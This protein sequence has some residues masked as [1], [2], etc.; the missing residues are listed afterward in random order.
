MLATSATSRSASRLNKTLHNLPGFEKTR[1]SKDAINSMQRPI[2]I[3]I[4]FVLGATWSASAKTPALIPEPQKV[5]WIGGDLDCSRYQIVDAPSAARFAVTELEHALASAKR[6]S[7][8][9]K[10]ILRLDPVAAPSEEAYSLDAK[11]DGI[12]I[13]APKPVGLLYGVETLRQLLAGTTKLPCCRITDWPAFQWRGF[14]HDVGRNF[15]DMALLK[16]FVNVMAHYKMNIFHFHLTDTPGYRIECR[17]HPELNDPKSYLPTRR[18]G[19]FYTYKQL[20]N[21]IA[22][23]AQRGIKVVPEIDMPG[24]SDLL[25]T[26]IRCNDAKR[27]GH[28]DSDRLPERVSCQCTHRVFSHGVG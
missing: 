19:K 15:Q 14:M 25:R 26:R 21:F 1:Y 22:Y 23:C 10:I 18:P 7:D 28:E 9:T 20:N 24:H 4:L 27:K 2:L 12:V 11:P 13:T 16:R 8:G 5:E 6:S 3:L 17:V